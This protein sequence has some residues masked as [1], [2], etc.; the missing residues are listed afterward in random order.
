[1]IGE[2]FDEVLAAAQA[3]AGWAFARLY[4]SVAGPVSGYLRC[5]GV[6]DPEDA[7]SDVFLAVFTRLAGFVG[8]E[9]QFRSWVF[10]IAHHRVVDHRRRVARRPASESFDVLGPDPV[11]AGH[12]PSA[13]ADALDQLGTGRVEQVLAQL[14]PDQRDVLSLRILA[15]L[16]VDQVASA[17]GKRP[18]AVKALQR[19]GLETLR[20]KLVGEGVPL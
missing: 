15:D 8:G 19:R 7:T 3:G 20:R 13:E 4:E 9:A 17:L 2:A 10:T 12:R 1:M 6:G 5:Q 16:T 11:A 14:A 18:G